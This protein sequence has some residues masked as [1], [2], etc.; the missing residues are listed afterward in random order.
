M[1]R[2]DGYESWSPKDVFEKAYKP[3]DTYL[4]R[5]KIEIFELQQ[6]VD[7]MIDFIHSEEFSNLP[8]KKRELI[9]HQYDA[10]KGYYFS[11]KERQVGIITKVGLIMV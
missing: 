4:N 3:A 6:K 5:M 1:N 7:K 10:M 9:N 11:L 8:S 2:E